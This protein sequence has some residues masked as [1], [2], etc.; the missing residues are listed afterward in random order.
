MPIEMAMEI[1]ILNSV[2]TRSQQLTADHVARQLITV[3]VAD[4]PSA[5]IQQ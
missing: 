2:Y 5:A 3:C 4:T 1:T